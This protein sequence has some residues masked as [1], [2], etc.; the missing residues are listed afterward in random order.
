MGVRAKDSGH[1][2]YGL[3]FSVWSSGVTS[4]NFRAESL[5]Q[6]FGFRV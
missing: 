4:F 6:R 2:V 5:N 3:G 1:R